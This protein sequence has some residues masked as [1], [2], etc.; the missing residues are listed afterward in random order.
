MTIVPFAFVLCIILCTGSH[1]QEL[2]TIAQKPLNVTESV[3][4]FDVLY[5]VK[6]QVSDRKSTGGKP[7]S[8]WESARAGGH[9]HIIFYLKY[10]DVT[11]GTSAK[12]SD[13]EP[14][15]KLPGVS[16]TLISKEEQANP[17]KYIY[18]FAFDPQ[19]EPR[20]YRFRIK[21][22]ADRKSYDPLLFELPVGVGEESRCVQDDGKGTVKPFTVRTGNSETYELNLHND[23]RDYAV[24]IENVSVTSSPP[25]IIS[26]KN[27]K[28]ET[29]PV[30]MV[31]NGRERISLKG[32]VVN[33]FSPSQLIQSLV[34]T[35]QKPPTLDITVSYHDDFEREVIAPPFQVPIRIEPNYG[36]L[37]GWAFGG[38][39][40]GAILATCWKAVSDKQKEGQEVPTLN[41]Q[42]QILFIVLSIIVAVIV[43][44]LG[45]VLQI[46][47]F[48][49]QQKV[50]TTNDNPIIGFIVGMIGGIL[51]PSA[52][53]K[54]LG[55]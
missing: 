26:E 52:F 55:V 22:T 13:I 51:G 10:V 27:F 24:E 4:E 40:L 37:L 3:P 18:E 23:F 39:T 28:F 34:N 2:R 29:S 45:L 41:L 47:I 11:Q 20:L 54:W 42:R 49:I 7:R 9:P 19:V 44:V 1:A 53:F 35:D 8:I 21:I 6:Q 33:G 32:I 50:H 48:A 31:P 38:A 16:L 25:G 5:E 12:I 30:E 17:K 43:F 36:I 15:E 14:Y 46:E